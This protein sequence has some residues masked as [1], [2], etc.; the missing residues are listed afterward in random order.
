MGR[1]WLALSRA[2]DMGIEGHPFSNQR[3]M[4]EL[5]KLVEKKSTIHAS[6]ASVV[7]N[8]SI[9]GVPCEGLKF[10]VL[11]LLQVGVQF[12]SGQSRKIDVLEYVEIEDFFMLVKV[13]RVQ[14]GFFRVGHLDPVL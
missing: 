8:F 14:H 5:P 9:D 6:S 13:E 4:A 7:S 1:P 11:V 2:E 10:W 3:N 12:F